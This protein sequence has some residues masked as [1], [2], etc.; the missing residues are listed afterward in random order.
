VQGGAAVEPRYEITSPVFDKVTI[1]LDGRYFGGKRFVIETRGNKPGHVYIQ[2]A[3]LNGKA[4][5]GRFWITHKELVAGG[6]LEIELG[7]APNK[8]WGVKKAG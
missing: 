8:G 3:K 2:S 5:E 6:R 1:E 7:P 4:L